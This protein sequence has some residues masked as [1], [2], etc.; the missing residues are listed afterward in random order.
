MSS[1]KNP[2]K[3]STKKSRA[4]TEGVVVMPQE[5]SKHSNKGSSGLLISLEH[6][7]VTENSV[8]PKSSTVSSP[9][10]VKRPAAVAD[11]VIGD[12]APYTSEESPTMNVADSHGLDRG[13][14][15]TKDP[16]MQ[17]MFKHM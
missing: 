2:K 3:Q 10:G 4:A 13:V 5:S 1:D 15:P 16:A 17:A 14:D 11:A 9:H 12:D 7:I 6:G 8:K